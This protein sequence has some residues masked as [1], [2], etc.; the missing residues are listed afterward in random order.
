MTYNIK[1]NDRIEILVRYFIFDAMILA[2]LT[3]LL[4]LSMGAYSQILPPEEWDHTVHGGK[5]D[6]GKC[7]TTCKF[8]LAERS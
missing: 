5:D 7:S 4:I 3:I 2:T 1:Y 8:R 6:T